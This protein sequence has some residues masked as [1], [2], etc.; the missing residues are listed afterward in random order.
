MLGE[1]SL[2]S[3]LR[4]VR[5]GLPGSCQDRPDGRAARMQSHCC[6]PTWTASPAR[7]QALLEFEGL[8]HQAWLR[9]IDNAKAQLQATLLVQDP[10]SGAAEFRGGGCRQ[11]QQ[12]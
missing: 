5:A 4:S 8:W 10:A 1:G 3:Q 9:G 11:R 12:F 7:W 2:N 6:N